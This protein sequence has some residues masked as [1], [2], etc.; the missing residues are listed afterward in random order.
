MASGTALLLALATTP[1]AAWLAAFAQSCARGLT[2]WSAD[3]VALT[4]FVTV[5][6]FLVELAAVPAIW[7]FASDHGGQPAKPAVEEVLWAALA[8]AA[9]ALP[10][11]LVAAASVYVSA[12]LAGG[13]WWIY[14]SVLMA[15]TLVIALGV[16]PLV[17]MG[18][19][20]VRPVQR[21]DLARQLHALT[22]HA[23]VPVARIDEWMVDERA[24]STA[25]VAGIGRTRRVLIA[26]DL[27]RHW[28]DEEVAVVVAHELSHLRHRDLWWALAL[29]VGTIVAGLWASDAGLRLLSGV[30]GGPADLVWL[31]LVTLTAGGVWLLVTPLR[32]M[33][34]RR[35]ER[36][37]DAFALALTGEVDAF[38][39]AVRRLGA[40]HLS[41]E[42]PSTLARWL[43]HRHPSVADRLAFAEQYR[44]W[45]RAASVSTED[46]RQAS[47]P[48]RGSARRS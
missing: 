19:A 20:R 30:T 46:R 4:V 35:H 14:A 6:A 41:E 33:Q 36:Q 34:S 11:A 31:P 5:T 7:Y 22:V 48:S 42:R 47:L 23:G 8:D 29:N 13:D 44:S 37:A 24:S 15:I 38:G 32:H 40:K 18:I 10:A 45:M 21:P 3:L 39:A 1:A 17:L 12:H 9:I 26:S 43:Y 16:G 2:G 27:L 28:S 25:M